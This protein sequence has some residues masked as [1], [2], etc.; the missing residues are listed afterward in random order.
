MIVKS[1]RVVSKGYN[2]V[3]YHNVNQLGKTNQSIHA[4]EDAIRKLYRYPHL[5]QGATLYVFRA[6]KTGRLLMSK[7]CEHCL[8]LIKLVGIKRILY[9]NYSFIKERVV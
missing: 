4:E 6:S 8:N 9:F 1:G 7:P 5:L 2:R 3:G